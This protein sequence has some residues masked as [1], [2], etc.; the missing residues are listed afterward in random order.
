MFWFPRAQ[1]SCVYII[2]RSIRSPIALS[3]NNV[4]TLIKEY[5][6]AKKF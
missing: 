2:L 3:K 6:I 5:F 4:D 1:G